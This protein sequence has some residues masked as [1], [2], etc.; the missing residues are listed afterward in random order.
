M[1]ILI[2]I[3]TEN[4]LRVQIILTKPCYECAK[5]TVFVIDTFVIYPSMFCVLIQ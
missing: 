4:V 2:C 3:I 5:S 1:I